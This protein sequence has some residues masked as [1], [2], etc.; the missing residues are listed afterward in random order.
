MRLHYTDT[1][2]HDLGR[3]YDFLAEK[4]PAAARHTAWKLRQSP[5]KLLSFPRMGQRLPRYHPREVRRFLIGNYEL[6]YEIVGD[7][8]YLLN[9]WHGREDRALESH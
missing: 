6:R 9:L 8:I 7:D 4:N 1:F 5:K 3:M 2:Q